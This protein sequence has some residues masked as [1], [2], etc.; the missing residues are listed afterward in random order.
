MQGKT[1]IL[2]GAGAIASGYAK[3]FA[4]TAHHVVI[5]SRGESCEKLADEIQRRPDV[6]ITGEIVPLRADASDFEQLGKVYDETFRRF[7]CIDIVVNGAGGNVPQAV[8]SD[9]DD[10]INMDAAVAEQMMASNYLSKYYSLQHFARYLKLVSAEGSV[11]NI[12][13]MSGLQPLSKVIHYS[14]AFAAVESLTRSAAQL[15]GQ[16]G[17]GRVNSIAV[18]FT[19]GNQNRRLLLN[20][21]GTPTPRAVDILSGTSQNRFLDV[22]EIAP[23]VLYLAD[24]EKSG[25]INGHSLRVDAGFNLV[26]L[27]ASA[28]YTR[29]NEYI[30]DEK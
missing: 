6:K 23:Y 14:A 15:F 13:S 26:S 4:D 11:V 29:G 16:C 3:L 1:V 10:F 2:F 8:V 30:T 27:S 28:G 20:E 19:I 21:D 18:G 22:N 24:A 17:I 7:G 12:S 9:L 25:A 5:V